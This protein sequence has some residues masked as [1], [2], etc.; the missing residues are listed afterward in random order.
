MH[1][2]DEQRRKPRIR[3]LE[4]LVWSR[5]R[6][7]VI[8]ALPIPVEYH[9]RAR[10]IEKWTYEGVRVSDMGALLILR[11]NGVELLNGNEFI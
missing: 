5:E 11:G 2:T 9:G 1:E 3:E 7:H 4:Q 6:T 10:K 8:L